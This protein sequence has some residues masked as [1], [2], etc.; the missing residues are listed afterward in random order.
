MGRLT[1]ENLPHSAVDWAQQRREDGRAFVHVTCPVC[2]EVRWELAKSVRHRV[3]RGIFTGNC[4][5][6]ANVPRSKRAPAPAHAA[7]NWDNS[8]RVAGALLVEVTCPLCNEPRMVEAKAV[9][10][11]L[12]LGV[13]TGLCVRDRML[14]RRRSQVARPPHRWVDWGALEVVPEGPGSTRRRT[15]VRVTCPDCLASRL[16]TP[17]TVARQITE[18][19]F[20]ARCAQHRCRLPREAVPLDPA[21]VDSVEMRAAS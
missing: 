18:G 8:Q 20:D 5:R 4:H 7:I 17:S 14:G 16:L 19:K 13:F 11:Q 2:G 6:D 9:R 10:H 21:R 3:S 12:K 1:G 15:K